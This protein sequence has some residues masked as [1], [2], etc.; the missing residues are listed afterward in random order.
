[1]LVCP[2]CGNQHNIECLVVNDLP[3]GAQF[4]SS[5]PEHESITCNFHHCKLCHHSFLDIDPVSYYKS[6]IRSISVSS[7]MKIFRMNQ[8]AEIRKSFFSNTKS[9]KCL[10]I[11]AGSGSYSSMLAQTFD[12][13]FATEYEYCKNHLDAN[14]V[15]FINTHP[16]LDSFVDVLAE[17]S[18]YDFICCF[19]YLEHLPDPSIV[20]SKCSNLLSPDGYL[21]IEVPNSSFIL[22]D[23]LI[24]EIIPDHIHYFSPNSLQRLAI[25]ENY[26][27]ARQQI[28]WHKYILSGLFQLR[29]NLSIASLSQA[30][31]QFSKN[32]DTLLERYP[33]S[34]QIV[35]WGAGHQSLFALSYTNL[36]TRVSF[37]VDSSTS[38]QGYV[39][40]SS[41]LPIFAPT[42]L[43]TC[44]VDLLII[45]CAG[46]NDE[47][48][49]LAKSMN[50]NCDIVCLD[51]NT[52][53]TFSA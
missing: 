49:R 19:S 47:V 14:N 1:M 24:N 50:L 46:Y 30:Q 18:P 53:K 20:F 36:A 22:G 42:H 6:V 7:E 32:V 31:Y 41:N 16:D 33:L 27:V 3:P 4:F 28:I 17:D 51:L 35:V 10:E 2:C 8:F 45:A 23:A 48:Y 25:K 34:S 26:I 9:L 29:E 11:G 43:C 39:T 40:P 13:C 44:K 52:F 37:V 21:L 38:K 12:M 15:K 5:S